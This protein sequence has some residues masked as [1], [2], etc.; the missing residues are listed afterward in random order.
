[1]SQELED[2]AL[3]TSTFDEAWAQF[4]ETPRHP[5]SVALSI[6]RRRRNQGI[7]WVM[8]LAL[9]VVMCVVEEG[10]MQQSFWVTCAL[11]LGA[12]TVYMISDRNTWQEIASHTSL[13]WER[14]PLNAL[15]V[16][17]N[18]SRFTH[19]IDQR[20]AE[21]K[22]DEFKWPVRFFFITA[23]LG[24]APYGVFHVFWPETAIGLTGLLIG[25][26]GLVG[27]VS[28][29][30]CAF[31]SMFGYIRKFS[32]RQEDI[33]MQHIKAIAPE[34]FKGDVSGGLTLDHKN[35]FEGALGLVDVEYEP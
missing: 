2:D 30:L 9:T 17:Q 31:L 34:I 22:A 1:M 24:I 29:L 26:G 16:I 20:K 8:I 10:A 19:V 25:I 23:I 6:K 11:C 7:F 12:L 28:L 3:P 32:R 15:D 35:Q 33:E 27:V 5:S 18:S 4:I 13:V 21:D 14:E